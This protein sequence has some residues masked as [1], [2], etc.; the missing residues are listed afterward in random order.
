LAHRPR[1]GPVAPRP[2]A[3]G[4]GA[5]GRRAPQGGAG[6]DPDVPRAAA[7]R[8][9]A[10]GGGRPAAPVPRP[11]AGGGRVV[12]RGLRGPRTPLLGLSVL[13]LGP[14]R[15]GVV[16]RPLPAAPRRGAVSRPTRCA[17][18]AGPDRLAGHAGRGPFPARR[19][20]P[21]LAAEPALPRTRTGPG[22][23]PR[24]TRA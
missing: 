18:G 13:R 9:R 8:R 21:G 6:R 16:G 5:S 12:R 2:P 15:P 22:G 4:A 7:G 11:G 19:F 10:G 3:T 17:A 24:P 20:G 14:P 1:P 23:L